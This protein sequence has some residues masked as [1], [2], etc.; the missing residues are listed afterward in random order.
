M[1]GPH[2]NFESPLLPFAVPVLLTSAF[3][4][5]HILEKRWRARWGEVQVGTEVIQQDEGAYRQSHVNVPRFLQHMP[6]DLEVCAYFC[7]LVGLLPYALVFGFLPWSL[8]FF[9]GSFITV[10]PALLLA[11]L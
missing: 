9:F 5:L 11:P 10:V 4:P 2:L 3:I 7:F 6:R 1:C 8:L